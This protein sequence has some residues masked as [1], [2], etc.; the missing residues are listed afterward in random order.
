MKISLTYLG[1]RNL[2]FRLNLT[3]RVTGSLVL[4]INSRWIITYQKYVSNIFRSK[5]DQI[6]I[7]SKLDYFLLNHI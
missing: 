5:L 4:L 7:K 3:Q 2:K 6:A 1:T